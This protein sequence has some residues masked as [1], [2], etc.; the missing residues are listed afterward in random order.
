LLYIENPEV[1][2]SP[3]VENSFI[4]F[5]EPKMNDFPGNIASEE[6]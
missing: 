5:G 1:F 6:A 3:G 4:I 2:K